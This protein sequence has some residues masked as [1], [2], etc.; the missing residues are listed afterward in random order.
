MSPSNPPIRSDLSLSFALRIFQ[1][2]RR[3]N[4]GSLNKKNYQTFSRV[5]RAK[6]QRIVRVNRYSYIAR[7]RTTRVATACSFFLQTNERTKPA[8][9]VQEEH[10]VLAIIRRDRSPFTSPNH[11]STL[12]RL[13]APRSYSRMPRRDGRSI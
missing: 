13:N 12:C 9:S 7:A 6:S 3:I 10:T 11:D 2:S 8:F 4:S 5:A 1:H